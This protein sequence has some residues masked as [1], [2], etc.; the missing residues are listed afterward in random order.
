M[1]TLKKTSWRL[2][3]IAMGTLAVVFMA[4]MAF[5]GASSLMRHE[6]TE[7]STEVAPI[8]KRIPALAGHIESTEWTVWYI[9]D[10]MPVVPGPTDYR[11]WGHAVID[12][13]LS[14]E[15]LR[16]YEWNDTLL[17][18]TDAQKLGDDGYSSKK[19]LTNLEFNDTIASP[20]IG[21]LYFDGNS[22]VS[23][24]MYTM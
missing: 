11:I 22:T 8:E 7:T 9:S 14:E 6:V 5:V 10:P 21:N 1:G 2:G 16:H 17:S 19:W 23:F 3:I 24:S 15:L 13:A 20:Y 18:V 12:S 4:F